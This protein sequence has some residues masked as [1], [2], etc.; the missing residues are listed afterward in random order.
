MSERK[1]LTM[2]RLV[3]ATVSVGLVVG[4]LGSCAQGESHSIAP[5]EEAVVDANAESELV[6]TDE[7]TESETQEVSAAGEGALDDTLTASA[8]RAFMSEFYMDTTALTSRHV[9]IPDL[10]TDG[11]AIAVEVS[12]D[13]SG[14]D[15]FTLAPAELLA[16][17]NPFFELFFL[18]SDLPEWEYVDSADQSTYTG[19]NGQSTAIFTVDSDG[20]L[21]VLEFTSPDFVYLQRFYYDG[22]FDDFVPREFVE[23]VN[24]D[25][26]ADGLDYVFGF[27]D[28]GFQSWEVT[29]Y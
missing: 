13:P 7:V 29:N 15:N 1:A 4:L 10:G 3:L 22:E 21:R 11:S 24:A 23:R 14:L 26:E 20:L 9:F 8:R 6:G 2:E 5:E 25:R 18:A 28:N 16:P 12:I 27:T 17:A 19:T